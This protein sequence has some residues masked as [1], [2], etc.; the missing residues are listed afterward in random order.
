MKYLAVLCVALVACRGGSTKAKRTGSAAPVEIL[1]ELPDAGRAGPGATADEIEPN[2]GSEVATPLAMGGTARGKLESENDIDYYRIQVDKQGVLQ[3]M[4]SG[5]DG[6]DLILELAD[7]SATSLARSDR[8]MIRIKEGVPNAGVSAGRY[9]LIVR[10]AAKKKVKQKKGAA[11]PPPP[12]PAPVYELVVQ[13]IEPTKGSERE[14]DD[15]RG[16][17]NDLIVADNATGFIGWSND[18]DVWKLSVETLSEKNALDIEVSAVEGVALEL[19]VA[20][21]IGQLLAT[22]K[23]PRG[24]PLVVRGLVPVVKEGAPPFHYVTIKG[25][26]SNPETA[27]TLHATA[28]IIGTDE[29][30]EPNDLVDKPAQMPPDRTVVHATWTPGDVDCFALAPVATEQTVD[31]SVDTPNEINLDIELLVDG[32]TVAIANKAGKGAVEKLSASV[33]ANGRPVIRI[34]NPDANAKVEAKYDLSVQ[35]SGAGD[36]AP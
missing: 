11:E 12:P 29:E 19:E 17:A 10:Q 3:A 15:D 2:D 8:G 36:N 5:V 14:P 20:D 35:E 1:N 28:H 22:R 23:A 21:G 31:V 30:L 18:R 16:T 4:L 6:Q 34:K 24:A 25:D 27:Y 26:K 7:S 32:K 9:D 33:P 13:L